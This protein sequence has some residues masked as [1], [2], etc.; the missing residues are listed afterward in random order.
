MSDISN[1]RIGARA[2]AII[3]A[4]AALAYCAPIVWLAVKQRDLVYRVSTLRTAPEAAGFSRAREVAVKTEDGETLVGWFI[5][6]SPDKPFIVYLHG[7]GGTLER[8]AARL[9]RMTDDGAGLLAI[10]WRGYGGST[11]APSQEGLLSDAR[12]AYDYAVDAGA[13]ARRIVVVGESLGTG[14]ALWLAGARKVAAVVL[15]SPY[16]SIVEIGADRYW[17]FPVRLISRDPFPAAEWAKKV[18]APVFA[19]AGEADMTIPLRYARKL[20]AAITAPKTFIEIPGAGHVVLGRPDVLPK[21]NAW[22]AE[23]AR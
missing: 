4:L 2:A 14:P 16:S 1:R 9:Q 18:T 6:P 5:P 10:E 12:A 22:I 23:A 3:A 20:V 21:A 17:M 7:N 15:D 11:G 8:R 19:V 13:D